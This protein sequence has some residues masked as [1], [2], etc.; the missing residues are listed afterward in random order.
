[1]HQTSVY[2][3]DEQTTHHV[4]LAG[5]LRFEETRL[6]AEVKQARSLAVESRW[7]QQ[8]ILAESVSRI[9]NVSQLVNSK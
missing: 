6:G 7:I 3:L 2:T 5:V 1:M 9:M 8:D 4:A